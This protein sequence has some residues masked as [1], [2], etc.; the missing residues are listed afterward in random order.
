MGRDV[1]A[2]GRR[3]GMDTRARSMLEQL[4]EDLET[5]WRLVSRSDAAEADDAAVVTYLAA[6]LRIIEDL[7][8]LIY[9]KHTID[10]RKRLHA[11]EPALD[12]NA[13]SY[14]FYEYARLALS[15][16]PSLAAP[17][18]VAVDAE[19]LTMLIRGLDYARGFDIS[20]V[21]RPLKYS[22]ANVHFA[23]RLAS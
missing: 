8:H 23:S 16:L 22:P 9:E 10:E 6:N 14:E 20:S 2:D 21:D 7:L 3:D 11:Q 5:L 4:I 1:L 15:D 18:S 19:E 12:R 13:A 17:E